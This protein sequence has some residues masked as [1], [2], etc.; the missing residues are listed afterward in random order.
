MSSQYA[1]DWKSV[2]GFFLTM[3]WSRRVS[4]DLDRPKAS[5]PSRTPPLWKPLA[6]G[7]DWEGSRSRLR[8]WR[9][10]RWGAGVKMSSNF[11]KSY[12]FYVLLLY[13][14]QSRPH[15]AAKG[16]KWSHY[17]TDLTRISKDVRYIK[18]PSENSKISWVPCFFKYCSRHW[19]P[20][21]LNRENEKHKDFNFSGTG[22]FSSWE[23]DR[24]T[25]AS[26]TGGWQ[27]PL[28]Q[29]SCLASC[30]ASCETNKSWTAGC[31]CLKTEKNS[32]QNEE[33]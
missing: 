33:K 19:T 27:Q 20:C 11:G 13:C 2:V 7:P 30:R 12:P 25:L 8:W 29:S 4:L 6:K 1:L 16:H 21:I 23:S 5:C 10:Q 9:R 31:K 3:K 14:S 17:I 26:K 22:S 32:R 15:L 18:I 28:S 24:G